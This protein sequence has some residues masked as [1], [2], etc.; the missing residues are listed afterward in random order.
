MSC[1]SVT[2]HSLPC[3]PFCLHAS[4]LATLHQ[5]AMVHIGWGFMAVGGRGGTAAINKPAITR[6]GERVRGEEGEAVGVVVG[7]GG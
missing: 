3:V 6:M 1:S 4:P 7:G 5:G 2:Y